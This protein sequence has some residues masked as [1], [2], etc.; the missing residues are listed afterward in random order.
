[1][2]IRV[3]VLDVEPGNDQSIDADLL[4]WWDIFEDTT[5]A[6]PRWFAVREGPDLQGDAV[7]ASTLE[8]LADGLV[9]EIQKR[10]SVRKEQ[11]HE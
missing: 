7:Y 1:M 3:Q 10:L 5:A 4:D 6:R 11:S 8:D 2:I 9:A